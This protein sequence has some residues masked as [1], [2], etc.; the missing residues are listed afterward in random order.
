MRDALYAANSTN[1]WSG[2]AATKGYRKCHGK[3][4][5]ENTEEI[6]SVFS[7]PIS[8]AKRL[9]PF[10]KELTVSNTNESVHSLNP[11]QALDGTFIYFSRTGGFRP[12]TGL[13]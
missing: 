3:R 6:F 13:T 5:T 10:D 4:H 2:R 1:S 12:D 7:V 9:L 8:V 11:G